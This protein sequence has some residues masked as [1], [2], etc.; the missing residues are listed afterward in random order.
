MDGNGS[1]TVRSCGD[2]QERVRTRSTSAIQL[3]VA[4]I[5]Q[6]RVQ[7]LRV[8]N[9]VCENSETVGGGQKRVR[10][11]INARKQL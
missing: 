5:R 1:E 2:G 4:V 10:T 3:T 11:R 7:G 9:N 6:K 8:A